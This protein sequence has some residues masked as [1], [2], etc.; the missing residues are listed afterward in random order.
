MYLVQTRYFLKRGYLLVCVQT[1]SRILV[2]RLKACWLERKQACGFSLAPW[3][4]QCRPQLN[5]CVLC[6]RRC[7]PTH[8]PTLCALFRHGAAAASV[9]S[10]KLLPHA[11]HSALKTLKKNCHS[12]A[13][14]FQFLN[15]KNVLCEWTQRCHSNRTRFCVPLHCILK[16]VFW[17]SVFFH[18]IFSFQYSMSCAFH[19][20]F[21]CAVYIVNDLDNQSAHIFFNVLRMTQLSKNTALKQFFLGLAYFCIFFHSTEWIRF[22]QQILSIPF[23]S[24]CNMNSK[25]MFEP[26]A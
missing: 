18:F 10:Y 15:I 2:Q 17:P 8:V 4:Q 13:L 21:H 20:A 6:T 16:M 3:P 9:N 25:N 1:S 5:F 11:W 14:C 19:C 22:N 24:K 26:P 7:T 23:H 12:I